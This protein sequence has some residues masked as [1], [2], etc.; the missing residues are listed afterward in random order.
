MH[1]KCQ[2]IDNILLKSQIINSSL[3]PCYVSILNYQ[4][5]TDSVKGIKDAQN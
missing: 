3:K 4:A 5:K 2:I 1:S